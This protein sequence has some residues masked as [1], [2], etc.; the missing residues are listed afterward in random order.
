MPNLA[1]CSKFCFRGLAVPDP[2]KEGRRYF[3]AIAE[4][5]IN[6]KIDLIIPMTEHSIGHLNKSRKLLPARTILACPECETIEKIIDKNGLYRLAEKLNVPIPRTQY[7]DIADDLS[8]CI[9]KIKSYPVVVKPARSRIAIGD[10]FI[11][12]GVMYAENKAS[13]ENLY[14]NKEVLKYPSMIQ[15]K[16]IGPGTGL[17]TLYDKN[18]H[19]AL[20]S[21]RRIREKPPSGGVSVVSE[22]VPLDKEMVAAA[23]KLLSAVGWTGVAMVEFKRDLRDGK[24]KLME[25]NGRFW[26]TLQLAVVSGVDFP[27]LFLDYMQGKL[28]TETIAY[29]EVGRRLKWLFGAMDYFLIRLR[30]ND[31][32]L[33]LKP[34]EASKCRVFLDFIRIIE[35]NTSFD[36]FNQCDPG[37]FL[38]EA[39]TYIKDMIQ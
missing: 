7:I 14:K 24:A 2:L 17:F 10:G 36:V 22:S 30:N 5:S 25:I 16:I 29:Y 39:K 18:R 3:D 37:P 23:D 38:Q 26:G 31:S 12:S 21:H 8:A 1:S 32:A 11:S 28:P 9:E 34:G 13:L 33:H 35:K 19:L 15:E 4:I 27:V 6:W 20:F